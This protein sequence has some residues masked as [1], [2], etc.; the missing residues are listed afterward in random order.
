MSRATIGTRPPPPPQQARTHGD[1]AHFQ[2][3]SLNCSVEEAEL[4]IIVKDPIKWFSQQPEFDTRQLENQPSLQNRAVQRFSLRWWRDNPMLTHSIG[5]TCG[6]ATGALVGFA[7]G[8]AVIPIPI[9]GGLI[10]ALVGLG[11]SALMHK[12]MDKKLTR[13]DKENASIRRRVCTNLL[14]SLRSQQA[15]DPLKTEQSG[16]Q[17]QTSTTAGPPS[18]VRASR[19]LTQQN[20]IITRNVSIEADDPHRPQ[21]KQDTTDETPPTESSTDDDVNQAGSN[22]DPDQMPVLQPLK[23]QQ[24]WQEPSHTPLQL[25]PINT[26]LAMTAHSNSGLSPIDEDQPKTPSRDL[27]DRGGSQASE[28][29]DNQQAQ[30]TAASNTVQ[31]HATDESIS[32]ERARIRQTMTIPGH[33]QSANSVV[34]DSLNRGSVNGGGKQVDQ[35][36]Q[37]QSLAPQSMS[38]AQSETNEAATI[39]VTVDAT[40]E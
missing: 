37:K 13:V 10:G 7:V 34:R 12:Y 29:D 38:L 33:T 5:A 40:D 8:Q 17:T 2:V 24:N 9:I 11:G 30:Q 35:Q 23:W 16:Q 27:N 1:Q 18:K 32:G 25:P 14:R 19:D 20:E 22:D 21:K 31:S 3:G 6:G 4:D 15:H 28:S 39:D 26:Q 36:P